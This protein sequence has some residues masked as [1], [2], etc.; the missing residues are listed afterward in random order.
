MSNRL[1][2]LTGTLTKEGK[3]QPLDAL[4]VEQERGI[5]VKAH[6]ATMFYEYNGE[7]YLLNLIDTPGH[8]DFGYEVSRSLAASQGALLIIDATQG[9]QAQT[10]A[11]FYLALEADLSINV[12]LNKIDLNTANIP[13]SLQQIHSA[14]GVEANEVIKASA[15]TG[16]GIDEIIPAIIEKIPP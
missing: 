10:M 1:L 15:K 3:D 12:I 7:T 9:V 4:R 8:V 16:Q 13:S 5:T 6:T 11:N 14:F 2:E